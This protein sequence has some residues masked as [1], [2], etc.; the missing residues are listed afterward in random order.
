MMTSVGG[1]L[2][3]DFVQ[4]FLPFLTKFLADSK[5]TRRCKGQLAADARPVQFPQFAPFEEQ[6]CTALPVLQR[7]NVSQATYA[8]FGDRASFQFIW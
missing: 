8:E 2:A 4:G 3:S 6:S 7:M 1:P 5:G